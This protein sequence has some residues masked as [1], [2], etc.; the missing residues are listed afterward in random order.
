VKNMHAGLTILLKYD[1]DGGF[2]AEHHEVYTG[3][4]LP[5]E[6]SKEDAAELDRLGWFWSDDYESWM[7]FT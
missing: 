7:K 3:G 1:P 2:M 6:L 5:Q 4:P